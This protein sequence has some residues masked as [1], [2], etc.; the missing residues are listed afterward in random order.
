M[1]ARSVPPGQTPADLRE[2]AEYSGDP[3]NPSNAY[4]ARAEGFM[5]E[6]WTTVIQPFL[7]PVD[8]TATV[9]LAAGHGRNSNLLKLYAK[10]LYILD[11]HEGNVDRCRERFAEDSRFQF[12]ANNGFDLQPVPDGWATLVYCFDAMVHFDSDVV[13]SYLRDTLRV[14]NP[15]CFGFFHHSNYV[16]GFDWRTNPN[17]R[18]FMSTELFAHC[19]DKEGLEVFRQQKLDWGGEKQLDGLTLVRKPGST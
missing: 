2:L 14:L 3:W 11:I 8:F 7:E 13:R 16:G 6:S 17:S 5:D 19:A 1:A 9:D 10:E 18:S 12:A 4:F 15:G